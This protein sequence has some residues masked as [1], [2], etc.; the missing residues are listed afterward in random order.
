MVLVRVRNP[1]LLVR[2]RQG[3]PDKKGRPGRHLSQRQIAGDI[4]ISHGHYGDIEAGRRQPSR[5]VGERIA[6][7]HGLE[8]EDLFDEIP[9]DFDAPP[10]VA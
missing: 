5:A 10:A 8:L 7:Y 4:E 3:K 1:E 6:K 9:L 2:L